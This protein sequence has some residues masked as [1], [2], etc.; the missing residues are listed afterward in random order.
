MTRFVEDTYAKTAQAY[1][2]E[3][4]GDRPE[5][6]FINLLIKNLKQGSKILDL[7]SGPGQFAKYL[8]KK[9]FTVEG[10]D[11]SDEMLAIARARVPAVPFTKMDMRELSFTDHEFDAVL[12]AY[13]IIH[14]PTAELSGV[15]AEIKRVLKADG[16]ALFIVQQGKPDQLLDVPWAKGEKIFVNFFTKTRI[17]DLLLQAGFSIIQQD[18]AEQAS[19]EVLS[20]SIVIA[21]VKPA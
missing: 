15:L 20:S 9:G 3:F 13:S 17:S 19:K 10:I 16:Y 21:L 6:R 7:G 18:T 4:F 8:S 11:S 2:K 14:I 12:A 5:L 1:A